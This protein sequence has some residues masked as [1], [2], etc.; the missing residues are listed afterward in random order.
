MTLSDALE[1]GGAIVIS[2]G[3]GSLILI[4]FSSWLGKV[5]AE[6][7]LNKE[8]AKQTQDLEQF[9]QKLMEVVERQKVKL[10]KSEFIF[11]KQF[12]AT[13]ALV[14]LRLS[15]NP[16]FMLPNMEYHDACDQVASDFSFIEQK[17]LEFVHSHGAVLTNSVKNLL[18]LC[19]GIV[20]EHKFLTT[21]PDIP[22]ASNSAAKVSLKI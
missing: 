22:T 2:L 21:D 7:I 9:K 11:L 17:L 8:K 18:Y 6:R 14:A 4:G 10:K 15:I 13:S 5:W 16:K 20:G 12:E 19:T 3:G 1:V